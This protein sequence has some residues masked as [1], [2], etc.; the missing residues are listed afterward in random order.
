MLAAMARNITPIEQF[1][2]GIG[3]CSLIV[4]DDLADLYA[5]DYGRS[6][7]YCQLGQSEI[8]GHLFLS[9]LWLRL[10]SKRAVARLAS[11]YRLKRKIIPE[12]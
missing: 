7:E 6:K 11:A 8:T 1:T 12:P 4:T 9:K 3:A 2:V 5:G 10:K